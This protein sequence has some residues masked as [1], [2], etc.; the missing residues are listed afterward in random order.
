[1]QLVLFLAFFFFYITWGGGHLIQERG[2][3]S[4]LW[5]GPSLL[6]IRGI[7]FPFRNLIPSIQ[8]GGVMRE[9]VS[10]HPTGEPFQIQFCFQS[11]KS[12][13]QWIYVHAH[14]RRRHCVLD[15]TCICI[16]MKNPS[17][18]LHKFHR[19]SEMIAEPEATFPFWE[20]HCFCSTREV[21]I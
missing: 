4:S 21:T 6:I 15:E 20:K 13:G 1:M 2:E 5:S 7:K 19:I 17:P 8:T 3:K 16:F 10:A 9:L 11:H 12:E 18:S 14:I